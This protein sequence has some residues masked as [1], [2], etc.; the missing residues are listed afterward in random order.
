MSFLTD[1]LEQLREHAG[2]IAAGA[3]RITNASGTNVE[4]ARGVE[5]IQK[6]VD[7]MT[8]KIEQHLAGAQAA[9][10]TTQPAAAATAS[11]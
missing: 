8:A 4:V 11:E 6:H 9:A 7:S 5:A 1:L 3:E 10:D 2:A